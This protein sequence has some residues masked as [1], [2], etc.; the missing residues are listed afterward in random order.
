MAPLPVVGLGASQCCYSLSPTEPQIRAHS[1]RDVIAGFQSA[2]NEARIEDV[3]ALYDA[4]AVLSPGRGRAVAGLAAIQAAYSA[5]L[6]LGIALHITVTSELETGTD[7][8]LVSTQWTARRANADGT[9]NR[10][11]GTA[12]LVLRRHPDGAWRILIDDSGRV[13]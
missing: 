1:P 8:A 7:I 4:E 3:L 13:A 11:S 10:Q 12:R 5:V 2:F 6:G 9:R